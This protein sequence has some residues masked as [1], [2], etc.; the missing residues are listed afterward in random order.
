MAY[1]CRSLTQ[2]KRR[3]SC[4]VK[5]G[6]VTIGG[7][8]DIVVQTMTSTD[9]LDTEASASQIERIAAVGGQ[10]V[11]L[12]AQG[13]AQAQN[14][15]NIKAALASRGIVMPLVADIHF[16]P[17]AALVAARYVEK[18]R[19]NPG[20]F[21]SDLSQLVELIDICR[22]RGSAIRIGINHG[23]LSQRMVDRHGDT[24]EGMV[25]SAIEF[26]EVC[27]QQSFDQVVVSMKS[28]NVRVMVQA[29]RL[30][31][32]KMEEM[33]MHYP[34][35]LGVTEAGNSAQGRIKSAMG[36]G[37]LLA[38]GIGD[39]IRVSLTENPENEI[40]VADKLV[41]YFRGREVAS[42]LPEVDAKLYNPYSFVRRKSCEVVGIGGKNTPII[43]SELTAE[44]REKLLK[45]DIS[46]LEKMTGGA[47]GCSIAPDSILLL[48][49]RDNTNPS[50]E[51]RAAMLLLSQLGLKNPVL[52]ARSY[53]ENNIEDLQI[54]AAADLG[55]L[56]IDGFGDGIVITNDSPAADSHSD[57]TQDQID[58]HATAAEIS[59]DQIDS[60]SLDILQAARLRMSSADYIACPSCGRTLYDIQTTLEDIKARTK[61]LAGIKIG[62]MGCIVNGP[63]EMADAD[64]GY[65]GS[66]PEKITLYRGKELIKRNIDQ[67]LAIDE[68]IAL[69]KADGLWVEPQN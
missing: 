41:D 13:K 60:L 57:I 67:S 10:L 26:L 68:L 48:D 66:A 34:L 3:E 19:I 62:V 51:L 17:E 1:F 29:Y 49:S 4:P 25:A 54:K 45:I 58:S 12:T 56:L 8:N 40:P 11:R 61:H 16:L 39:T 64:Y 15:E 52:F 23:S 7:A 69:I 28:S 53:S 27:A 36:I 22:Q 20:N 18:V 14:L 46:T 32:A 44:Q 31:A 50:L 43:G 35:H 6:G 38:D 47:V 37:T 30:L 42:T 55:P 59:Q 5:V 33:G 21:G 24:P 9:T 65:V 63:G 2:Y